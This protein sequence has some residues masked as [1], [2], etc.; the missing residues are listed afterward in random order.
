M[1]DVT[2]LFTKTGKVNTKAIIRPVFLQSELYKSILVATDFLPAN[3]TLAMRIRCIHQNIAAIPLC[4][5]CSRECVYRIGLG[6]S[7]TCNSNHCKALVSDKKRQA[8][9][10]KLYGCGMSPKGKASLRSRASEMNR[11]GRIVLQQRYGVINPSQLPREKARRAAVKLNTI[12]TSCNTIQVTSVIDET[13]IFQCLQCTSTETLL[14]C[15]FRWRT[16]NLP[17]P[18]QKCSGLVHGSLAEQKLAQYVGSLIAVETNNRQLIKPQ[19]LDI[20]IPSLKIAI[21]YCG[22]YWHSTAVKPD[23]QYHKKKYLACKKQ[24]IRLITI[25]EDEWLHKQS[26]VETKLAHILGKSSQ[27][28]IAARDCAV[29]Q[30]KTEIA[31]DHHEANHIQGHGAGSVH[32]GLYHTNKLVAVMSFI[33]GKE[34]ILNRYSTNC[35]VHGG[36]NKLLAHYRST[37]TEPIVSFADLRWSSGDIYEKSGFRL[38]SVLSPDYSYFPQGTD[39]RVHKFNY[40]RKFLPKLLANFDPTLSESENT[41]ANGVLKIYDCGKNRYVQDG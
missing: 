26:I 9:R 22:L 3:A 41:K 40:R 36:F 21:E 6:F 7:K 2:S 15:T 11:K 13:V 33:E 5:I 19:E 28:K 4:L 30:I 25:F 32:L 27:P 37:N 34:T 16:Q 24:G 8:T 1:L 20:Y 17:T 38:D 39:I 10:I 29:Q 14:L 12:M 31:R 23:I 35:I 18:C